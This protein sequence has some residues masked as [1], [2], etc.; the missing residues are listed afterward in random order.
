MLCENASNAACVGFACL[1][2]IDIREPGRRPASAGFS[3]FAAGVESWLDPGPRCI[4]ASRAH[5]DF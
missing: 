3:W 5:T 4:A 1:S 2:G